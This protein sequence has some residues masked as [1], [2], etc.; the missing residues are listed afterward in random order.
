MMTAATQPPQLFMF[1]LGGHAGRANIEVHDVQFVACHS[2]QG[3]VAEAAPALKAAWFG[4]PGKLHIDGFQHINWADGHDITLRPQPPAGGPR[5]YFVNVG[6]YLPQQLAE[7]HAFGLFAAPDADAAKQKAKA[8]LL[9]GMDQQHK[10][11]L[12]SVDDCLLLAEVGG[13]HLHL[14]PNP[15]GRPQPPQMQGYHPI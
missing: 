10:D 13:W 3:C 14:S 1:Y 7:Q 15:Q 9:P 6:G 8:V 2:V 11:N 4:D 5:L 12:K